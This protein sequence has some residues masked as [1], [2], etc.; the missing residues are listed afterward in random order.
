MCGVEL[1]ANDRCDDEHERHTARRPTE[2]RRHRNTSVIGAASRAT[3]FSSVRPTTTLRLTTAS[4]S[5]PSA[6]RSPPYVWWTRLNTTPITTC[7][8]APPCLRLS[9]LTASW[10]CFA[11]VKTNLPRL[12]AALRSLTVCISL[13]SHLIVSVL[14]Y[15][16][17]STFFF[18][19]SLIV[20]ASIGGK[21]HDLSE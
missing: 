9:R 13:L 8:T 19:E 2:H 20:N 1:P 5:T 18:C 15:T 10:R 21:L 7:P 17:C 12:L 11:R 4:S 3:T 6:S 14:L 16:I